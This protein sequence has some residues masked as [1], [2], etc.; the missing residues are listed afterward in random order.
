MVESL[1][2]IERHL[3][4][5]ERHVADG[6]RHLADQRD[7]VEALEREGQDSG[8]ARKLLATFEAALALHV[9]GRDRLLAERHFAIKAADL[10]LGLK[11]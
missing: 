8:L 3:A 7:I 4:Q 6:T 10:A 11:H 9:S 1:S 2:T 5:A